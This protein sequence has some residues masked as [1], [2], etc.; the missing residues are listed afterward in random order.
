MNRLIVRLMASLLLLLLGFSTERAVAAAITEAEFH[1]ITDQPHS[2]QDLPMTVEL[3]ESLSWQHRSLP[4][5]WRAS[6]SEETRHAGGRGWYRLTFELDPEAVASV[7]NWAIY[8]P[9]H[10]RVMALYVNSQKIGVTGSFSDPLS[11]NYVMPYLIP[12][13]S[14]LLKPGGNQLLIHLA[15]YGFDEVSLS[16]VFVDTEDNLKSSYQFR[17]GLSVGVAQIGFYSML[18]LGG[19]VFLFWLLRRE[20]GQYLWFSLTCMSGAVLLGNRIF[21]DFPLPLDAEQISIFYSTSVSLFTL[22]S[23]MFLHRFSGLTLYRTEGAYFFIIFGHLLI[24][25]FLPTSYVRL[26]SNLMHVVDAFF[27]LYILYIIFKYRDRNVRFDRYL[28]LTLCCLAYALSFNDLILRL[29]D[30]PYTNWLTLQWAPLLMYVAFVSLVLS[31]LFRTLSGFEQL[32]QELQKRVDEKSQQV[33]ELE[34]QQAVV[35]E[36]R[37]IMFDLHDGIGGQL[38]NAVNYLHRHPGQDTVLLDTVN[39]ALQDLRLIVDSIDTN[40]RQDPHLILGTFRERFEPILEAQGIRFAWNVNET[41]ESRPLGPSA[42]LNLLRI[43]QEV[44]TNVVKHAKADTIYFGTTA[45][46]IEIEDNGIGINE[47][48]KPGLGIRSMQERAENIGLELLIT[49][50]AK[51]TLV[52]LKFS[53]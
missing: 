6:G 47:Q 45:H 18:L 21:I 50:S 5:Y 9:K 36:R 31:R 16:K 24:A 40:G 19:L 7:S 4:D 14:S 15:G 49:P 33:I 25:W 46:T 35:E 32:T 20:D 27:A 44:V 1:L 52:I 3:A 48:T 8:V 41:L 51:G 38:V 17:Y 10:S 53:E 28:V 39:T 42:A 43:L 26:A 23:V 29:M 12:V 13:H 30:R 22:F 11:D 34:R 2:S 37:R